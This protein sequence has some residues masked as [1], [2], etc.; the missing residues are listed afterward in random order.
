MI[1]I[2]FLYN[3]QIITI[4]LNLKEKMR[5]IFKKFS[6]KS[7]EVYYLYQGKTINNESEIEIE[8]IIAFEDRKSSKMNIIANKIEEQNKNNN[9]NQIK[10]HYMPDM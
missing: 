4:Q 2:D 10:I 1:Q 6:I 9:I 7:Q 8:K 3:N 5:E